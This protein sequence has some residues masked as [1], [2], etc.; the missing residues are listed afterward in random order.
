L[1]Y[2]GFGVTAYPVIITYQTGAIAGQPLASAP[3]KPDT[4]MDAL[5][6]IAEIIISV[7]PQ[8]QQMFDAATMGHVIP[9][10]ESF[11]TI[12]KARQGSAANNYMK[13]K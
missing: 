5:E 11:T 8:L 9:L 12:A 4:V 7:S 10:A 3:L 2:V 1:C 6:T 13:E